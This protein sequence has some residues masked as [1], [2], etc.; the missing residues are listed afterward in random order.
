MK[1]VF[2]LI[3]CLC[4]WQTG[5]SQETPKA[6]TIMRP[7][8]FDQWGDVPFSEEMTH[9]DKIAKQLKEWRLSVVHLVIYAGQRA[10]K[11]EAKARGIRAKNHLLKAQIEPERIVWIDGGWKKGLAVEAWIWPPELGQPSVENE[12]KL[13]PSEIT[14]ERNCK[15][16]HRGGT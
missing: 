16:K 3:L 15:I 1:P 5:L 4:I 12:G 7:D 14:I 6:P 13:K 8:K 10:C 2:G 11:G 9:L